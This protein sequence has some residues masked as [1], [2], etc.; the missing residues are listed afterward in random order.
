MKNLVRELQAAE[1]CAL[2]LIDSQGLVLPG[3]FRLWT[4]VGGLRVDLPP[5]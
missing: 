5:S 1:N 3:W 4:N 2:V